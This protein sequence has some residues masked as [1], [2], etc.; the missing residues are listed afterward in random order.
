[1]HQVLAHSGLGVG[2]LSEIHCENW[3]VESSSCL[4]C[5]M[6]VRRKVPASHGEGESESFDLRSLM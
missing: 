6:V 4:F 2:L 3:G 1:M 5:I